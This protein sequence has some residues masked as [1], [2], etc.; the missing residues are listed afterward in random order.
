[1][2]ENE[3]PLILSF[4]FC[5]IKISMKRTTISES[6]LFVGLLNMEVSNCKACKV[7]DSLIP[8]ESACFSIIL[9]VPAV[10]YIIITIFGVIGQKYDL[11]FNSPKTNDGNFANQFIS[12][13]IK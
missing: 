9:N 11:I 10:M 5:F 13:W 8:S 7:S 12:K 2:K 4:D 6:I 3:I 1:M